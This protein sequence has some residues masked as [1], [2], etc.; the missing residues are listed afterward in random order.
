MEIDPRI[1]ELE[2]KEYLTKEEEYELLEYYI[3][4]Q[5][6]ENTDLNKDLPH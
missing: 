6:L 1:R 4:L 5:M 2:E 3:N